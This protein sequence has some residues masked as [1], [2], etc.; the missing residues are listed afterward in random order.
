MTIDQAALDKFIAD[1]SESGGAEMSNTQPFIERLCEILGLP[2][3]DT[4]KEQNRLNDYVYERSVSFKH[5]DGTQTNGRIDLYKRN[6]FILEAKQSGKH[7]AS[8]KAHPDQV[9]MFGVERE[10]IKAGTAQRGTRSWDSAMIA[11]RKQAEGYA[12]ALPVDHGYPPFLLVADIG[13]VI[14]IYADFSGQGKNYA[15]FPD[16][17]SY[18]ITMEDLRDEKI[19]TRLRAIWLEPQSLDPTRISAEVTRDIANRLA[20]IAKR[21]EQ[22]HDA[23]EV[24]EFLMRCL[25]TM[26]AEDAEL[27][28]KDGFTNLLASMKATPKNF[29]PAMEELWR[30]MDEGG[31]AAA[32]LGVNAANVADGFE[33]G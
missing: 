18:R 27:L 32:E 7:G 6:C 1:F 12:R 14:E 10:K 11:A 8:A 9:D 17:Q 28:P 3:P 2:R 21:L 31:Y 22:K 15:H 5:P 16:R 26:F 30:V 24:A 19:Q 4:S 20:K 23:K 13:H 33:Q 25:F 29:K